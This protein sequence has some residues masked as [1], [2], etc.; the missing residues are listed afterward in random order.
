MLKEIKT[1]SC[2]IPRHAAI[3]LQCTVQYSLGTEKKQLWNFV[4]AATVIK[5]EVF[6]KQGKQKGSG[7]S[8]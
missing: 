3:T 5:I 6:S 7:T 2:Q 8:E 4:F 1:C